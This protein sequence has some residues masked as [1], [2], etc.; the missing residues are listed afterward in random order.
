MTEPQEENG[1]R[2]YWIVYNTRKRIA[3]FIRNAFRKRP[4]ISIL[5]LLVVLYF[6]FTGRAGWQ[7][8]FLVI[9]KYILLSLILLAILIWFFR[10]WKNRS[11][12]GNIISTVVILAFG[13]FCYF[14][15]PGIYKYLSLYVHYSELQKVQLQQLPETDFERIQPINSV[16]TLIDQEALSETEDATSPRFIRGNDGQYY[17]SCAVGP[18]KEYKIQQMS[19]DMYEVIYVPSELPA[20]VFSG[21]YRSEV[22]FDI[23]ELLLFSK[24][25]KSAVT[26]RFN[27]L[28]FFTCEP[29]E[30]L[31]LQDDANK[32]VQVIPVTRWKGILFPRPV[33][34]GVYVIRESEGSGGYF[35]RVLFG[36]GEYIPKEQIA[37]HAFLAGQNLIPK[38]VARF[39]AESFRFANG[40][41][42]PMPFY[43]EGDI[44]IP[45]LPNDVNPQPF[46]TYFKVPK[47][48]KLYN[49]FGLE[50]YQE[51]KKG[52]SLSL[53]IPGDD[54]GKVYFIDHRQTKDAYIGSSAI[55]AK[56][57]ESKK[58]YDWSKNSPAES[59]PFVRLVDGKTRFLWLSTIVTRAGDEGQFIGGSIPEIT[60]TDATHGKVVWI[61]Q[62]SL[63]HND[64]WILQAEKELSGYWDGE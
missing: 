44:R 55:G 59:R 38:K 4:A 35:S 33:F 2:L 53:L 12:K 49:F 14:A 60:L 63:V 17:Y 3:G 41:L 1:S 16:R 22:H 52:L 37:D 24:N 32:W 61:N 25:T 36:K 20:P 46:V 15:G 45:D 9:R 58:N 30:P 51:T 13:A 10:G 7:P 29:A 42:A 39:T 27:L 18:A 5:V 43:H 48:E 6:I 54:D 47:Q 62:D 31:Y 34:D 50:P 11:K 8:A 57:I 21:K 19:K 64:S 56:I 28:K 26:K 23:G 40:F